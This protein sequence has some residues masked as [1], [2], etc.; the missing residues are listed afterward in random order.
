MELKFSTEVV[1]IH[2]NLVLMKYPVNPE[3][4]L[5]N[6]VYK[7]LPQTNIET[8]SAFASLCLKKSLH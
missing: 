4:N 3:P 7:Q 5:G 6:L 2:N 1:S 8:L